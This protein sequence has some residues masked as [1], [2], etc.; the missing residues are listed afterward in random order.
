[1]ASIR[2]RV[3][4]LL[5]SS[6]TC[7]LAA[8]LLLVSGEQQK[9]PVVLA[10]ISSTKAD[11]EFALFLLAVDN[12]VPSD[13]Q[14]QNNAGGG[15]AGRNTDPSSPSARDVLVP[16][17]IFSLTPDIV[18]KV[19]GE[20]QIEA[21][22]KKLG[23]VM[24]LEAPSNPAMW[25]II[26]ALT[27]AAQ[28]ST[29]A[30]DIVAWIETYRTKFGLASPDKQR[31]L[32][33]MEGIKRNSSL[34][35][36][37]SLEAAGSEV[38]GLDNLQQQTAEMSLTSRSAQIR[39]E[40]IARQLRARENQFTTKSSANVFVCTWNVNEKKNDDLEKWLQPE[41]GADIIAI[42]LQ[43][44]DMTAGALVSVETQNGKYWEDVITACLSKSPN[45][46]Y[47][48]LMSK[49]LV[50]ILLCVFV[51][52]E[53]IRFVKNVQC[54]YQAVGIMGIMGNKGGVAVRMDF[55]ETTMCYV[56]AH[57]AAHMGHVARRNQNFH[58]IMN[59]IVFGIQ[60]CHSP[61]DHDLVFFF[62]DL[63]YRIQLPDD[64]V[65]ARIAK[66]EYEHLLRN[67][68]LNM[69]KIG[70]RVFQGFVEGKVSFAPT[71]KYDS[72]SDQYDTSE[73][74]RV[75]SWTDRILWRGPANGVRQLSYAR[76]EIKSSDHRPVYSLF[77]V[78]VRQ[79]IP[80]KFEEVQRDVI[81]SLDRMENDLLP[82]CEL[83]V[84]N[85]DFHEVFYNVPRTEVVTVTNTGQ[86][87]LEF[88]FV[89]SPEESAVS[90]PWLSV[91]PI[92]G[93]ILPGEKATIK[94]TVHMT[95][96]TA[97][98][99]NLGSNKL[100]DILILHLKNGR[101]H[102]ISAQGTFLRS[103]FGNSLENLIGIMGPVRTS[104]PVLSANAVVSAKKLKVP[105]ELWRVVDFIYRNAMD[106]EE[107][108]EDPG[109]PDEVR[110]IR[111][112][113]D[114]NERFDGYNGSGHSVAV[115]LIRFLESLSPSVIPPDVTKRCIDASSSPA[116]CRQIVSRL[117]A[118]HFNVFHYVTAFLREVL[119]HANKNGLNL[120]RC[121]YIF[122]AALMRPPLG[123]VWKSGDFKKQAA[124]LQHFLREAP[125]PPVERGLQ[126][127]EVLL[128]TDRE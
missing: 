95:K 125:P 16:A 20:N 30:L 110:F 85:I 1:M 5:N 96:T 40:W 102:F 44:I 48:R 78:D 18:V 72:Y 31:G 43:E 121:A 75:P 97:P 122:S 47:I 59:N 92:A 99:F 34:F 63:N 115:T 80:E 108:F 8:E 22:F 79:I 4:H 9:D 7:S 33:T 51:K 71:Y 104:E 90:K 26:T 113:L 36:P 60:G 11:A 76:S 14:R 24:R 62:G 58:D 15:N 120:E 17:N 123:T 74:R 73:K 101:D 81:K 32:I 117:P 3:E 109:D 66:G 64:D 83:D 57:L 54:K 37:S 86:V 49:Q 38:A 124:F 87:V 35:G 111:E 61:Y 6:E 25:D 77:E 107:L 100:E 12:T 127:G 106:L 41:I 53:H 39:Q 126:E 94:L 114:L 84:Q 2:S 128:P 28:K 27:K 56:T 82:E 42:G 13:V 52:E 10:L 67:E 118:V 65:R 91:S 45:S 29:N 68:Q 23:Q 46:R 105:K 88:V 55:Y 119:S 112:K 89:P 19:I 103:S 50:G 21:S 116:L 98:P 93:M 70:G 69:E